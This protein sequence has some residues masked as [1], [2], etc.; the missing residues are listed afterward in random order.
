MVRRDILTETEQKIMQTY[1][2][3]GVK[4]DG[5]RMLKSRIKKV[6]IQDWVEQLQLVEQ[7]K[8]MVGGE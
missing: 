4:L 5:Y 7:F 1:L 8:K 2:T 3:S 6:D